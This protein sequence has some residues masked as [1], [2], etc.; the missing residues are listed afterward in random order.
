MDTPYL[1]A[2][3]AL[4]HE[5]DPSAQIKLFAEQTKVSDRANLSVHPSWT[6]FNTHLSLPKQPTDEE[7]RFPFDPSEDFTCMSSPSTA[8]Q[9]SVHRRPELSEKPSHVWIYAPR[10]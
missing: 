4:T 5:S 10:C 6:P 9:V 1:R 3:D 7:F 2:L 8:A